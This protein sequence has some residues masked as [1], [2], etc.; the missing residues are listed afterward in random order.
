MGGRQSKTH[1]ATACLP[2]PSVRVIVEN[3]MAFYRASVY[4]KCEYVEFK[5]QRVQLNTNSTKLNG[6]PAIPEFCHVFCNPTEN[7]MLP[8]FF[9]L[10][11]V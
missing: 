6:Y 5:C 10:H 7:E 11:Y 1:S 3:R 4:E 2:L 8:F 9:V